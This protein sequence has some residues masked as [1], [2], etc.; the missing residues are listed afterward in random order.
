VDASG[1]VLLRQERQLAAG[2]NEMGWYD[3]K[4]QGL[5]PGLYIVRMTTPRGR[6]TVKVIVR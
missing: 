3:V 2:T 5:A 4:E 1:R 6:T